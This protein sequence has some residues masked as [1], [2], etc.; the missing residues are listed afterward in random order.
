MFKSGVWSI[1]GCRWGETPAL[2]DHVHITQ[3]FRSLIYAAWNNVCF[4][5]VCDDWTCLARK[6]RL[7]GG[8]DFATDTFATSKRRE[9]VLILA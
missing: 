4:V 2:Q 6:G 3:S 5:A 9:N 8:V 1:R 7:I